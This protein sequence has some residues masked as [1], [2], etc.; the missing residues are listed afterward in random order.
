MRW[1][2]LEA[3]DS[4]RARI[5]TASPFVAQRMVAGPWRIARLV[6]ARDLRSAGAIDR[7]DDMKT[8]VHEKDG[9][10]G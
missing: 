4:G 3:R 7:I 2:R 6:T 5:A 8:I 9:I 10:T 1:W